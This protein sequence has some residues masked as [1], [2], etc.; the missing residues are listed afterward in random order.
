[1]RPAIKVL[2]PNGT[3]WEVDLVDLPTTRGSP[4]RKWPSCFFIRIVF[5][6]IEKPLLLLLS[7]RRFFEAQRYAKEHFKADDLCFVDGKTVLQY[8]QETVFASRRRL[9]KIFIETF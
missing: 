5:A 8:E 4:S 1:M 6:R 3:Y 2:K 9:K 7:R